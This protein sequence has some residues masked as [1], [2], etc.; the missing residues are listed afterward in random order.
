MRI[1]MYYLIAVNVAAWIMYGLDKWKARSGKWRISERTLLIVALIGGSV[2]AL[3]GML[4]FRH[5][6][7]KP[8]FVVGIPVMLVV[9][10]VIVAAAFFGH[11][12]FR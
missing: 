5:K 3:T 7:K 8:K 1:L 9:H 2:G 11:V 12:P 6:T 4:M 10:C